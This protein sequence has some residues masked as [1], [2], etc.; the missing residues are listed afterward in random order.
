MRSETSSKRLLIIKPSAL[1]DVAHALQVVPCLKHSGWCEHL[2]WLVDEAYVDLVRCCPEVDE[3]L[4]YPRSRWKKQF[5]ILEIV[6]WAG[7]LRGKHFDTVLD[8]QGLARSGLMSLATGAPRRIGLC[9]AREGAG[10]CYTERVVDDAIH[11]V[12]RYASA[13][14]KLTGACPL[15]E[16][17]LRAPEPGPLPPALKRGQFTLL[18]PYSQRDEKC[19]PWRNYSDLVREIPDETFV[20]CGQGTWFPCSGPNVLDL[21][22]QTPLGDLIHLIDQCRMMISTDSGPLHIASAFGKPVI[23]LFGASLPERTRPRGSRSVCL[24]N[25]DFYHQ[26]RSALH[27]PSVAA[28]AMDSIA[29]SEVVA[30]WRKLSKS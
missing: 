18:H 16:T 6:R 26:Q 12:D 11:A 21:R 17:T 29:V 27:R 4:T 1:G 15:P 3:V 20:L 30:H 2:A 14:G 22:N 8:L 7:K 23:G 13:C 5:S 25:P 19:W 10:F 9:S 24:W 28:R